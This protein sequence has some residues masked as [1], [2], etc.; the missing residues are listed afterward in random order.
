MYAD[1]RVNRCSHKPDSQSRRTA[2]K[3]AETISMGRVS[4]S[5]PQTRISSGERALS[6]ADERPLSEADERVERTRST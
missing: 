1:Y 6:E 5:G 2:R 3:Q 4:R